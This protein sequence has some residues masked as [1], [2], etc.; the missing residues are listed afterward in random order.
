MLAAAGMLVGLVSACGPQQASGPKITGVDVTL[1]ADAKIAYYVGEAFSTAGIS[2]DV[3]YDDNTKEAVQKS[4]YTLSLAEGYVFTAEDVGQKDVTV[5]YK[6]TYT[7]SFK[8]TVSEVPVPSWGEKVSAWIKDKSGLDSET[9]DV[10]LIENL[11]NLYPSYM[12]ADPFDYDFDEFE[13]EEVGSVLNLFIDLGALDPYD[14]EAEMTEEQIN[15][16]LSLVYMIEIFEEYLSTF[17]DGSYYQIDWSIYDIEQEYLGYLSGEFTLFSKPDEETGKYVVLEYQFG[18]FDF[19]EE[20]AEEHNYHLAASMYYYFAEAYSAEEVQ[21]A[22]EEA[23]PYFGYESP[24]FAEGKTLADANEFSS[25]YY[26][27]EV[28]QNSYGELTGVS[29]SS[30][31]YSSLEENTY[32]NVADTFGSILDEEYWDVDS[33]LRVNWGDIATSYETLEGQ[34]LYLQYYDNVIADVESFFDEEPAFDVY[35]NSMSFSL[36]AKQE[37]VDWPSEAIN[38]ALAA[39]GFEKTVFPTFDAKVWLG[40]DFEETFE[41]SGLDGNPD[42]SGQTV[43]DAVR[44]LLKGEEGDEPLWTVESYEFPVDID[45]DTFSIIYAEGFKAVSVE[46]VENYHFAIYGYNY[47]GQFYFETELVYI[48]P[49]TSDLIADLLLENGVDAEVPAMEGTFSLEY[50]ETSVLL[51]TADEEGVLA[52]EYAKLFDDSWTVEFDEESGIYTAISKKEPYNPYAVVEFVSEE[53]TFSVFVGFDAKYSTELANAAVDELAAYQHNPI[54]LGN[55]FVD[56]GEV[57]EVEFGENTDGSKYVDYY[58]DGYESTEEG[59][60]YYADEAYAEYLEWIETQTGLYVFYEEG[61]GEYEYA[62]ILTDVEDPTTDDPYTIVVVQYDYR[63]S[64]FEMTITLAPNEALAFQTA[65]VKAIISGILGKEAVVNPELVDFDYNCETEL[66]TYSTGSFGFQTTIVC[67]DE[68][69]ANAAAANLLLVLIDNGFAPTGSE[70]LYVLTSDTGYVDAIITV[71]DNEVVFGIIA[72]FLGDPAGEYVCAANGVELVIDPSGLVSYDDKVALYDPTT[73]QFVIY[74]YVFTVGM[75]DQNGNI[76]VTMD[77]GEGTYE[78]LFSPKTEATVYGEWTWNGNL[79]VINENGTATFT[80]N[81]D[82][83]EGSYNAETGVVEIPALGWTFTLELD[84]Q[85]NLV[86]TFDDGEGGE[87]NVTFTPAL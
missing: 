57:F 75:P 87:Y 83:F 45:L 27:F 62:A 52:A 18:F 15:Y 2:V 38:G 48:G 5:T 44:L 25:W 26:D 29:F 85:G 58:T 35:C 71:N 82:T 56:L 81:V 41:F 34:Q 40:E 24:L 74:G 14:E 84:D 64:V 72:A 21:E 10:A 28:E 20:G 65:A 68:D 67:E 61:D 42:G 8:L 7:A 80:N 46:D 69:A 6:E 73:R 31:V 13:V 70:G 60:L 9:V 79:L 36:F 11:F 77:D 3:L 53:G 55:L 59:Y 32:D 78:F 66:L 4:D 43:S 23:V 54:E 17:E 30:F 19:A 1:G 86:G 33:S 12:G 22:L 47:G 63:D 49:W 51:Y 76:V 39:L 37:R 16:T 50:D